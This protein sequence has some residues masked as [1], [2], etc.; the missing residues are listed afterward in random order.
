MKTICSVICASLLTVAIAAPVI[1]H[2]DKKAT[3]T[4]SSK[5]KPVANPSGASNV[6]HSGGTDSR[7]CHTNHTTGDYHCHNPK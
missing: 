6:Q 3:G 2:E 5:P 1:A 4:P 7:G